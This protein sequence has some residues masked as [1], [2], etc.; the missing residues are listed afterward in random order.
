MCEMNYEFVNNNTE[1]TVLFLHGWGLSGKSFDAIINRM[2]QVS[3]I[4][5]DLFG[6]GNSEEPK[7]YFD[8]Y[9]YAYQIFL[10]LRKNNVNKVVIVGHSFGGRLA[11]ILSSIFDIDVQVLVLTASAGLNKFSLKKYLKIKLFKCVKVLVKLGVFSDKILGK[12]GSRDYKD[13]SPKM[14]KILSK[15]VNQDLTFLLKN[16]DTKVMLVWDKK[17]KDTPYWICRKINK[18]TSGSQIVLYKHGG[19]FTAFRNTNKFSDLLNNVLDIDIN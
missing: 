7:S 6:F 14:Q 4:K 5:V 2:K 19:H 8:V 17:D 18:L 15:V 10:L 11:I 1:L 3:Y 9:E 12:F 13:A 16:I